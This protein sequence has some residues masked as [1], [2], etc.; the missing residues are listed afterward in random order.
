MINILFF[1]QTRERLKCEQLSYDLNNHLSVAE[2]KKQLQ[3]KN[4]LWNEVLDD[5]LLCAVNQK[6]VPLTHI[7]KDDDEVA[8]F[9]AVTGG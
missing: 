5:E 7:I 1:A 8:F 6:L 3:Q 2:L 9:P 4:S